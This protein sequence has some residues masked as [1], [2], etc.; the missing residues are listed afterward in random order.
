MIRFRVLIVRLIRRVA[1][2]IAEVV[3]QYGAALLALSAV[4]AVFAY[5]ERDTLSAAPLWIAAMVFF[6]MGVYAFRQV[7]KY[8]KQAIEEQHSENTR[9]E[10]RERQIVTLLS[11]IAKDKRT[12]VR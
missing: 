1:K 7:L 10:L 4:V 2:M 8:S 12:K 9:S 5:G 11:V 6:G 3:A